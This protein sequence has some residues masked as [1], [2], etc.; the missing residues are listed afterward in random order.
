MGKGVSVIK[1]DRKLK[2]NT[3]DSLAEHFNDVFEAI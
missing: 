2:V 1:K 3:L